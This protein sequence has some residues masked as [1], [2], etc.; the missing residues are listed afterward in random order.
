MKTSFRNRLGYVT[1]VYGIHI[2]G[3]VGQNVLYQDNRDST[4]E[5]RKAMLYGSSK[6]TYLNFDGKRVYVERV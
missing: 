1:D 4:G 3:Y 6:G 2:C 5:Q